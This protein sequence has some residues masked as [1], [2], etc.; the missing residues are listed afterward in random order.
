MHGA[1]RLTGA[2]YGFDFEDFHQGETPLGEPSA[3]V[4]RLL[5]ALESRYV[6][7]TSHLTAASWGIASKVAAMHGIAEPHTV[8]NVFNWA[9][10]TQLPCAQPEPIHLWPLSLYWFSQI[11]GLDRGLQDAIQALAY[12]G[13]PVVLHIRGAATAEVKSHLVTLARR[14]GVDSQVAFHEPVAPEELLASAVA[15]DIGLCLEV[16]V[17]INGDNC[18]SNKMFIY[19]LAGLAIIASR[20]TGHVQVLTRSPGIGFLYEPNDIRGLAAVIARLARDQKLLA[21]TKAQALEAVRRRWNWER[22]F[23]CVDRRCR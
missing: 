13:E 5:A 4:N 18:I 15:H 6:P 10:R 7:K 9:D 19:L 8:L 2:K 3:P 11:V 14:C 22:K 17:T 21:T 20:T 12:V 1:A 23:E 16:P